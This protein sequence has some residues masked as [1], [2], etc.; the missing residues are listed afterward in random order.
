M[1]GGEKV[2]D[3][4]L[5]VQ[6]E[7]LS[8][9]YGVVKAVDGV[10]FEVR[11]GEIFGLL[12]P[13]GAGKSTTL[14]VLQGLRRADSGAVKVLGLD[15][16]HRMAQIKR[17]IGV[18]LQRTNL[19]PDLTALAQVELFA[20]LYGRAISRREAT[21]LLE[22]VS[23]V[24]KARALPGRL[25]GGQQQR[26]SLALA[27]VNDPELIFLDEPTAGLDPQARR[28]VWDIIRQLRDEGRTIVLT[29]QYLEEAEALCQ[30]VAVMDHGRLLA[31]DTPNA[32]INR[33]DG[34][35]SL[36]DVYLQL[37]GRGVRET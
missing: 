24:E 33:S 1:E 4:G 8:K 17:R 26:L 3:C 27:L 18:Q 11:A 10:S 15:A 31:L 29:T 14:S 5:A 23:L 22:R 9:S 12:G 19:M 25:S 34:S 21:K 35:S 30:R 37:T 6:V 36:E 28:N 13:N 7:N 32:L 20:V 2:S 16:Q